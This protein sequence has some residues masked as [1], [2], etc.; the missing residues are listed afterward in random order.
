MTASTSTITSAGTLEGIGEALRGKP[1]S[2][3]P[4][5]VNL[6][7]SQTAISSEDG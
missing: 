6:A 2:C 1:S 4:Q 5:S 7:V 3:K